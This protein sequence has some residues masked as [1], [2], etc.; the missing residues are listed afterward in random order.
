MTDALRVRGEHVMKYVPEYEKKRVI[1]TRLLL[2]LAPCT[3]AHLSVQRREAAEIERSSCDQPRRLAFRTGRA[4]KLGSG[5]DLN[6]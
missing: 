1:E 6:C 5:D 2:L 3:T 4:R